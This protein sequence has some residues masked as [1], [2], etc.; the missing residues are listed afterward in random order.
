MTA[1]SRAA[2]NGGSA[3]QLVLGR[4]TMAYGLEQVGL[5]HCPRLAGLPYAPGL[6]ARRSQGSISSNNRSP[7][8]FAGVGIPA[9]IHRVSSR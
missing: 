9:V 6:V 8:S 1:L 4:L 5:G 3:G 7:I 2:S